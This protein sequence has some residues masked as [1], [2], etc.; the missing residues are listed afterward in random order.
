VLLGILAD[1]HDVGVYNVATRLVVLAAFVMVPINQA[2]G[3]RFAHLAQAH[4]VD[5]LRRVYAVSTG[6]ILRL[7]AP[8]FLLLIV[9]PDRLLSA[10]GPA[11]VVGA[12]VTVVLAVGK[13]IDAAT[14]PCAVLLNMSGRP[15]Y[16]VVANVGALALNVG[17][18]LILIPAAGVVGAAVAWAVSLAVVNVVRLIFAYRIVGALPVDTGT[19][20]GAVAAL[21]AF[22]VAVAPIGPDVVR[23]VASLGVYVALVLGLGLTDDDRLTLR[24]VVAR[25]SSRDSARGSGSGDTTTVGRASTRTAVVVPVTAAG[26]STGSPVAQST[27][28]VPAPPPSN[29]PPTRPPFATGAAGRRESRASRRNV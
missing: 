23:A 22:V 28:R 3:P 25:R 19:K 17:L 20:R 5:G 9:F 4:D 7:S 14:G 11:F 6:W 2:V 29:A 15:G 21:V 1:S 24:A 13:L 26:T 16:N 27:S 8:A 12:T 18:N 10:F